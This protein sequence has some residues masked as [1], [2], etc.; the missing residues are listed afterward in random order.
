MEFIRW[1]EEV[2]EPEKLVQEFKAQPLAT[3]FVDSILKRE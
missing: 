2:Y 1:V 3:R